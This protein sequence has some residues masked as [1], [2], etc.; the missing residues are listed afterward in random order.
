MRVT[1]KQLSYFVAL[2][3]ARSFGA[4]AGKVHISQPALSQQIKELE[5]GLGVSLV[6]RLPR[7]IRLTRAGRVRPPISGIPLE[8]LRSAPSVIGR[9]TVTSYSFS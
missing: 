3:E 4:A 2:A 8:S 9:V 7:D 6:E 5:A 1:I